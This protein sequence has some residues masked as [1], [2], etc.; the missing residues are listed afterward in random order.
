MSQ[1]IYRFEKNRIF[2]ATN[3]DWVMFV[4][5][6]EHK[7]ILRFNSAVHGDTTRLDSKED[8]WRI[9]HQGTPVNF[10]F[11]QFDTLHF[12]KLMK[13]VGCKFLSQYTIGTAIRYYN[14]VISQFRSFADLS[15]PLQLDKLIVF[16][17][18]NDL[19]SYYAIKRF[20]ECLINE[21]APSTDIEDHYVLE[22]LPYP[23]IETWLG[24]YNLEVKLTPLEI[25]F[26]ETRSW[27]DSEHL[28]GLS[29][30][31]LRGYVTLR[32]CY[33]IGLRPIQLF[34]LIQ[35]DFEHIC[36][37]FYSLRRPWAKKGKKNEAKIGFDKLSIS[38]ELGKAIY[39]L[40]SL[41]S[42]DNS[43]LLQDEDGGTSPARK[44]N[45]YINETLTRWGAE[46]ICKCVYDFR[47][48][49]GHSMAMAGASAADIAFLLG[50][51]NAIT[52]AHYISACPSIAYIREKALA[53]NASYGSMV[54]LLTGEITL[55]KDWQ[56]E[57]VMGLLGNQVVTGIGGCNASECE[58]NPVFN[59]YGCRDFSPFA[60]GNHE[61]VLNELRHEALN[62]IGVSDSA[63]QTFINPA[64]MKLE[65]TIEQVKAVISRCQ[66]CQHAK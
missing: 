30:T 32:I 44:Y 10:H 42:G 12:K 3:A 49:L 38:P 37:E 63:N 58:F 57:T 16:A 45:T 19:Q 2:D 11:D 48:N 6:L 36:D 27:H 34:K 61:I 64:V 5:G 66:G 40:I 39:L 29:Y 33:E 26:I 9:R 21:N 24:Y 59:C 35:T 15:L 7:Q 43:Q 62:V 52:A 53:K 65:G 23:Q 4:E 13:W 20:T 17:S 41:Q 51:V 28:G 8:V 46:G 55:A 60:D 25:Q 14:C 1:V 47:H 54:A 31:G 18:E 56:G 50:H 22:Q